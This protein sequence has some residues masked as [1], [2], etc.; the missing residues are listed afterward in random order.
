[1]TTGESLSEAMRACGVSVADLARAAGLSE[2]TVR[3][4]R[5]GDMVGSLHSWAMAADALGMTVG[6]LTG[7]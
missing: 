4:M 2:G 7:L 5:S 6:E 1:M 3:R